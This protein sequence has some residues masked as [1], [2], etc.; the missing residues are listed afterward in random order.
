MAWE[1]QMTA[2]WLV[3][4]SLAGCAHAPAA[5]PPILPLRTLHLY[6]TGVG[7]FERHGP[8]AGGETTLPVPAGHL[9]DALKTL[10]VIDRQGGVTVNGFEFA[11]SLSNGLARA[12]AGLPTG[13]EPVTHLELL[14]GLVGADLS[15]VTHRE[16]VRGRLIAVQPGRHT[17]RECDPENEDCTGSAPDSPT[18]VAEAQ[19]LLL[20]DDGTI[21]TLPLAELDSVRPLDP[22]LVN[23]LAAALDVLSPR[24]AQTQRA[25]RL[26][27]SHRGEVTLGYI[28]ETP[29]WRTTYRLVA[30]RAQPRGE[31]QSWALL[32]NDTDEDWRAVQVRL[33]NGQPDSFL[34]P[35]AAPRYAR[36]PLVTPEVALSTVPQLIDTTADQFWGDLDEDGGLIGSASGSS[37]GIGGLGLRGSGA[38]GAGYGS[39]T[40]SGGASGGDAASGLLRVGDLAAVNEARGE[41]QGVLFSFTLAEPV[42]LRAHGSALVPFVHQSIDAELVTLMSADQS[43]ARSAA[44]FTNTSAYTLP[45]GPIACFAEGVFAG[46][47]TLERM[48][49]GERA[50]ITFGADLDVAVT[51]TTQSDR[52]EVKRLTLGP[53]GIEEHALR[54]RELVVE[55]SNRSA[56]PRRVYLPLPVITNAQ[57]EGADRLDYH[58]S[59]A[60]PFAVIAVGPATTARR[61]LIVREGLSRAISLTRV[62]GA[63]FEAWLAEATLPESDRQVLR[64]ALP[65]Q[66]RCDGLTSKERERQHKAAGLEQQLERLQ[67]Y[68]EKAGGGEEPVAGAGEL[69]NRILALETQLAASAEAQTALAEQ[70]AACV[71]AVAEKLAPLKPARQ[72]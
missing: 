40:S 3:L 10:V 67:R 8:V 7:Y 44:L 53:T 11:A 48:K 33:V 13:E 17:A 27:A 70:Q 37:Y 64:A 71:E 59:E 54:H 31:L 25:V 14:A 38:G 20:G 4:I 60:T 1:A 63:A 26:L 35:L 30:E 28:A 72:P 47:S 66:A 12:L 16:S 57:V 19:L 62:T 23:R 29:V 42:D 18:A 56:Q 21:R 68:L 61:S 39:F 2:R 50:L 24:D 58:P 34:F 65:A 22:T 5:G 52:R 49:P 15:V 55:V 32:H 45:A 43:E 51:L 46:E 36:R 9:D 6:E 69:V 41:E